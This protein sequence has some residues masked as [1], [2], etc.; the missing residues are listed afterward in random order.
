[1]LNIQVDL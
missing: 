1:M